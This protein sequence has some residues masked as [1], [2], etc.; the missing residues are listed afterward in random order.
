ML[1]VRFSLFLKASVD[2]RMNLFNFFKSNATVA[3][4]V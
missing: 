4:P 1:M 3:M 2:Y